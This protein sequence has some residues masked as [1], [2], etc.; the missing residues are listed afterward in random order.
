MDILNNLGSSFIFRGHSDC[1]W[2]LIPSI[3]RTYEAVKYY[4]DW[5]TYEDD[6]LL[7]FRKYSV[8][9]MDKVP[10]TDLEWLIIAQNHG[11]P[12]RLLDWSLNPLKALFFSTINGNKNDGCVW[13]LELNGWNEESLDLEK[14]KSP[15]ILLPQQINSRLISQEGCFTVHNFPIGKTHKENI[16]LRPISN[17]K[18]QHLLQVLVL[19]ELK[20]N[21]LKDLNLLGVNYRSLFPDFDGLSKH[22]KWELDLT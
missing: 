14:V 19:K 17:G 22:I 1:K 20:Q 9:Y 3:G 16:P 7:R 13:L 8:Q 21:I 12:T 4:E 6:L 10:S 18:N 5:K 15:S 11:L 2:E